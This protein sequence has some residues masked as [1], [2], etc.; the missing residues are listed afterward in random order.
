MVAYST[1]RPLLE[2]GSGRRAN[3]FLRHWREWLFV[4]A[5]AL[6]VTCVAAWIYLFR[7][8]ELVVDHPVLSIAYTEPSEE[9]SLRCT[10]SN[11]GR[12]AT[13]VIGSNDS[14][15]PSGCIS[16]GG[17]PVEI[18]PGSSQGIAIQYKAA[19]AGDHVRELVLY[20]DNPYQPVVSITLKAHVVEVGR[21]E[22]TVIS[23][24]SSIMD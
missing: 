21:Q 7:H 16:I 1:I 6:L 4:C 24:A 14:C 3:C 5:S 22:Q 20:T 15:G 10:L 18:R 13:R 8:G 19:M 12:R 11:V 17:L 23:S 2:V 9:I